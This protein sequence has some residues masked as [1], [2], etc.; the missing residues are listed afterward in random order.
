MQSRVHRRTLSFVLRQH[1]NANLRFSLIKGTNHAVRREGLNKFDEHVEEAKERSSW[2]SIWCCHRLTDCVERSM[3]ER[4][5]VNNSNSS[6]WF[7]CN[8]F[9][10]HS[11]ILICNINWHSSIR[12]TCSSLFVYLYC[13]KTSSAYARQSPRKQSPHLFWRQLKFFVSVL[14]LFV[15][16]ISLLCHSCENTSDIM[17]IACEKSD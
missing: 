5:S 12:H 6:T 7:T 4:V 1:I 14:F 3:H 10:R 11:I 9:R 2:R 8:F 17:C 15:S 16:Y 13:T